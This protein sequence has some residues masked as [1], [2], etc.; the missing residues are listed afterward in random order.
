L[1]VRVTRETPVSTWKIRSLKRSLL[2]MM[3]TLAPGRELEL[4]V[5]MAGEETMSRL[6]GEYRGRYESTDVL[7]FPQEDP[8]NTGLE[9]NGVRR[10]GLLGDVVICIPVAKRQA[11]ENGKTF[12]R[13]MELLA[14]HG[15]LHLFG[16]DDVSVDEKREMSA[17]EDRLIGRKT[18]RK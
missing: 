2:K 17:M 7:A 13:E 18:A 14:A 5:M 16:Y 9:Y 11:V 1:L 3:R 6:N 10:P 4:S 8:G 12:Y 15:L